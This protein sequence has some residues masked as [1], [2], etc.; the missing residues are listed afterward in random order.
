MWYHRFH[1]LWKLSFLFRLLYHQTVTKF[2][3]LQQ[4]LL[5][6][7]LLCS[8]SN[9]E[10]NFKKWYFVDAEEAAL[11]GG[12]SWQ[13]DPSRVRK[14]THAWHYMDFRRI[15]VNKKWAETVIILRSTSKPNPPVSSNQKIRVLVV[16]A[17]LLF[18]FNFNRFKSKDI[19]L[20]SS[21]ISQKYIK[22]THQKKTPSKIWFQQTTDTTHHTQIFYTLIFLLMIIIIQL[23]KNWMFTHCYTIQF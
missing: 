8:V 17:T 18:C 6:Q 22:L 4:M 19:G 1:T 14:S 16:G 23:S 21:N 9:R 12:W 20:C 2:I 11:I 15:A 5:L 7:S 3:W 10:R 13:V